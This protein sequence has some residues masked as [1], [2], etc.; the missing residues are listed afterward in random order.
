MA[1]KRDQFS[2]RVHGRARRSLDLAQDPELIERAS[3]PPG[4]GGAAAPSELTAR[5]E[6]VLKLIAEDLS[7]KEIANK[8]GLSVKTVETHRV[9]LMRKLNLHSVSAVVRYVLTRSGI[10]P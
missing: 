4:Q 2:G 8:L 1:G 9:N 7:S 6:Q 5:E 10:V 3:A